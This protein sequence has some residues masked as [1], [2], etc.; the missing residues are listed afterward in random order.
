MISHEHRF[1]FIEIQKTASKSIRSLFGIPGADHSTVRTLSA[2]HSD[3]WKSYFKFAF[4]RNP[5]DR[6]VSGFVYRRSGGN[7]SP[8]D[9]Q[10]AELY[11]GDFKAFCQKLETFMALEGENMFL[12]QH[13]W[14]IDESGKVGVDFIGHFEKLQSDW[15][16]ICQKL[17][18]PSQTIPHINRGDHKPYRNYY[19]T[20]TRD[21]VAHYYKKDIETFGYAF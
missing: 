3:I 2:Q 15:E 13:E 17:G 1:V 14:L 7:Q 12:S 10:W 19:D 18:I 5:W 4:V 16:Q 21:L 20:E 6:L 11:P 9:K 8:K